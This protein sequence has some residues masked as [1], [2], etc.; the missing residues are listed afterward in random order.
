MA[1]VLTAPAQTAPAFQEGEWQITTQTEIPGMPF[2]PPAVTIRQC[3]TL[4]DHKPD[5]PTYANHSQTEVSQPILLEPEAEEWS[6]D[7]QQKRQA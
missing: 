6:E 3:L 7:F 5:W 1:T 4:K 2:T